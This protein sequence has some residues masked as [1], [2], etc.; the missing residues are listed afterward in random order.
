[1]KFNYNYAYVTWVK[2]M[3]FF[4][5]VFT[6][7]SIVAL[8]QRGAAVTISG[9]VTLSGNDA[10]IAGTTIQVKGKSNAVNADKSGHYIISV[11][12]GATLVFSHVGYQNVEKLVGDETVINVA[13]DLTVNNLDQVVVISYGTRKQRDITGSVS[14]I[15]AAPWRTIQEILV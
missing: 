13:L 1:M 8:C 15:N 6:L 12:K 14:T 7:L 2:K 11:Q 3:T 10:D 5:V 9:T 4:V